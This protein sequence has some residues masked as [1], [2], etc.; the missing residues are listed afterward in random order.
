MTDEIGHLNLGDP[1]KYLAFRGAS[2]VSKL[3]TRLNNH[4]RPLTLREI[5]RGRLDAIASDVP[6][7]I[8]GWNHTFCAVDGIAI[9]GD[10]CAFGQVGLPVE[11]IIGVRVLDSEAMRAMRDLG[12]YSY[13][14]SDLVSAYSSPMDPT[15][16]SS[17][18]TTNKSGT[19]FFISGEDWARLQPKFKRADLAAMLNK[20]VSI[21]EIQQA[22]IFEQ[23]LGEVLPRFV[24]DLVKQG[25]IGVHFGFPSARE[26]HPTFN[27]YLTYPQ[28][29]LSHLPC[30]AAGVCMIGANRE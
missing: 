19:A 27:P 29:Q 1:R 17:R 14:L 18:K 16:R 22:A 25:E 6:E 3:I 12:N 21:E 10:E 2:Y 7:I 4:R 9:Y 23:I 28:G 30:V 20:T 13:T 8:D 11:R 24:A 26:D 15:Y 5:V